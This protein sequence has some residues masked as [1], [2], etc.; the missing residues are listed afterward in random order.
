MSHLLQ[1]PISNLCFHGW[2]IFVDYCTEVVVVHLIYCCFSY[3]S[4]IKCERK[5][6]SKDYLYQWSCHIARIVLFHDSI[7]QFSNNE[8]NKYGGVNSHLNKNHFRRYWKQQMC[9]KCQ[10]NFYTDGK[11][12]KNDL[13]D[14][15]F[16]KH[17]NGC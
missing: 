11:N 6:F 9:Y 17:A 10:S 12:L 14:F 3:L 4:Y 5:D 8:E 15:M 2:L 13:G 7:R 1:L 16:E